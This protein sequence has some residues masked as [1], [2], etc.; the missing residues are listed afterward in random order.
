MSGDNGN[1]VDHLFK[2]VSAFFAD[3]I[4][5]EDLEKKLRGLE[6]GLPWTRHGK[7]GEKVLNVGGKI[8]HPGEKFPFR[9][10]RRDDNGTD[11]GDWFQINENKHQV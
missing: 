7:P 10:I 4:V 11:E 6:R 5:V 8:F 2:P 1:K 3:G 9:G